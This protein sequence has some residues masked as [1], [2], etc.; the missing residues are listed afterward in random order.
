[1]RTLILAAIVVTFSA[2]DVFEADTDTD[3]GAILSF[4]DPG[5]LVI[6]V[7]ANVGQPFVVNARTFGDACVSFGRTEME[8]D[9]RNVEIRPYDRRELDEVC[10]DILRIIEH[11][12]TLVF[13]TPGTVTVRIVGRR[14]PQNQLDTIVRQVV[15]R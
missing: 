15:I 9:E 3:L 4:T 14:V 12:I 5:Q 2:C 13:N 10:A 6:P 11:P 8:I 1:M 7:A